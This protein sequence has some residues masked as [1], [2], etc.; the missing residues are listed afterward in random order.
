MADAP[1]T[2][3]ITGA[4]GGIGAA[5]ARLL[6]DEG[7]SVAG[8]DLGPGEDDA[9]AW[10]RVDVTDY[11]SVEAAAQRL[12]D[13]VALL[14]N[15]AATADRAPAATMT[16]EQWENV[17]RVD[18]SGT[19]YCCRALHSRLAV[20]GGVVVNLASIAG[21]GAWAGRANYCS[22]KAGVTMLTQ[23]L[24]LEWAADGIRV[25]AVSP[26]FVMTPMMR[27]SI[28]GGHL[29]VEALKQRTP[30]GRFAEDHE[31]A[32]AI[33][34]LAGDTFAFMTGTTVVIDGGWCANGG[35]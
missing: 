32:G 17:I 23:V 24:G 21:H 7:W 6:L 27:A 1:R 5:T 34:A 2:A 12:D 9:V 31:L 10:E 29:H 28:E 11:A 8:W 16:P 35:T 26:G 33:V 14:V 18:L 4:A 3:V 13:G 22:A 15:C 30:Q 25:V 19:F 20:G